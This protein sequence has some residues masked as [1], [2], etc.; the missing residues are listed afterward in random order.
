[1]KWL[2]EP[3]IF[4]ADERPLIAALEDLEVPFVE[5]KFGTPYEDY[6]KKLGTKPAVFHGSLQ[7]GKQINETQGHCIRVYCTLPKYECLYYYPRMTEY[8]LN[9]SYVMLPFGDLGRRK[10]YLFDNLAYKGKLFVRPSSG[11]K[12]FTGLA[13][14]KKSWD[15]EWKL[16]QG[17]NNPEELCVICPG[18]DIRREWRTVVVGDKVITGGQY[19]ERG[20]IVR[21]SDVPTKVYDFAQK[22]LDTTKYRPDPAWVLDVCEVE[23]GALCVVEPNSFSCAGLYACDY[24]KVVEAVNAIQ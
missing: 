8:L 16:R 12:T 24:K 17:Q 6:I 5:C 13:L 4:Q 14:D 11:Y 18:Y 10:D 7:F 1:M 21:N 19:A 22:V 15:E 9:S 23:T 3:E 2:L 20:K